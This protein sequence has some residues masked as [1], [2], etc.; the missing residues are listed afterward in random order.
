MKTPFRELPGALMWSADGD[1]DDF[2]AAVASEALPTG[3]TAAAA[4]A[5]QPR[6]GTFPNK[7][8]PRTT[9]DQGVLIMRK[10]IA[11]VFHYSLNGLL[12]DEGTKYYKFC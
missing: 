8:G 3:H 11:L 4:R 12:A 1:A 9:R 2:R 6:A 7:H 5:L 10:L